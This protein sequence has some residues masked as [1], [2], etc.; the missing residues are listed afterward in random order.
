MLLVVLLVVKMVSRAE[1]LSAKDEPA[2]RF[3]LMY[4]SSTEPAALS[5]G[6]ADSTNFLVGRQFKLI[7][8]ARQTKFGGHDGRQI[9]NF[10]IF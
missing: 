8:E 5:V 2:L 9:L 10:S 7:V 6:H 1:G 3:R 4:N